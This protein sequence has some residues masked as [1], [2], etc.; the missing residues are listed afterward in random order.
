MKTDINYGLRTRPADESTGR[1][2]RRLLDI[3][4]MLLIMG[5][6]SGRATQEMA[7]MMLN[8]SV[9]GQP[10]YNGVYL[11][12]QWVA[13]GIK[14]DLFRHDAIISVL[15]KN[16]S[17]GL[18][19]VGLYVLFA[20][21]LRKPSQKAHRSLHGSASFATIADVRKSHL[22]DDSGIV[23]GFFDNKGKKLLMR[24]D[25]PEHVLV[26][27]PTRSGKG[28]GV[29]I[30]TLLTW[31]HSVV[32]YDLK[33][34]NW[35]L[36]SKWR[37]DY[38]GNHVLR[39][40][41]ACNDGTAARYNPLAEIRLGTDH[42]VQDAQNI[43]AIVLGYGDDS[44]KGGLNDYFTGAAYALLVAYILHTCY[45]CRA[46]W[47]T[48]T[49]TDVVL[50][51]SDPNLNHK[52]MFEKMRTTPHRDDLP[53]P[54]CV[55]QATSMIK[56]IAGGAEKQFQG[57]LGVMESK[58]DLYVDP[59]VQKN[60][61]RSDFRIADLMNL[62]DPV[63]L[64]ICVASTDKDRLKPLTKLL[65]SQIIRTLT[66]EVK[67]DANNPGYK[68]PLLLL[69]DEFP[70]LGKMSVM[71]EAIAFLA[72]YGIRCM[73]IIQDFTQLR[74]Q[75]AYGRD[76][77]IT[78]N[79]KIRIATAPNTVATAKELSEMTGETTVTK[80]DISYSSSAKILSAGSGNVSMKETARKLLTPD[81]V[82]RL[83][84]MRKEG[85]RMIPGDI[86]VFMSGMP[87]IYGI[88]MLHFQDD[89][90]KARADLMALEQSDTLE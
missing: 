3:S 65:F 77:S 12:W 4:V 39:F 35:S 58:L 26:I 87:V 44:N 46:R 8:Q 67:T 83:N 38:A 36:S 80:Q 56:M 25:G 29:V 17:Y 61:S 59:I 43:A 31:P 66:N 13:W 49:L 20:Q 89:V 81:E 6:A 72:G 88:Q 85:K 19:V 10:F 51:L 60:I 75:N 71:N 21:F 74:D 33:K 45:D 55:R 5:I 62:D 68:H 73:L 14:L 24:H 70:S 32:I 41:P 54:V 64:Y 78:A 23:L 9:L 57:I 69:I 40:E 28:V 82:M 53:H 37:G 16:G 86:L 30:P 90:L 84:Q 76:E 27:A 2:G 52:E 63:S 50:A 1:G 48:A 18:F 7:T 79:C 47:A 34:E 42:D 22:L 15:S 11:P